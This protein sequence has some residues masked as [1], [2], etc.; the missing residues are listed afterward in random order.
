M[1]IKFSVKELS[2]IVGISSRNIRYYD[3]IGLFKCSGNLDNGYRYYTID[4]IEEIYII[5][6]LRHMG[7]SIKEIKSHLENRNIDEYDSI[8]NNQLDKV[9]AEILKL[10]RIQYQIK[11]RI[12][13]LDFI[14]S[15]PP[16]G[17]I[18]VQTLPAL[19]IIKLEKEIK[20]QID[21]EVAIRNIDSGEGLPTGAF[22]GDIGFFVDMNAVKTRAAEEFT[23]MFLVAD[24]PIYDMSTKTSELKSG[25]WL[26]VFV[27]GDHHEARMYYDDLLDY[28]LE[29]ELEL[30]SYAVERTLIDH[31]ISSDPNLHITE[32]LIP[33]MG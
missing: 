29:H 8:L 1:D 15:I 13:S 19:R 6:Y 23:G 2:Q 7:I 25:K 20:G 32:I 3:D 12:A 9:T 30:D 4:K 22:V 26:S 27:K 17:E 33:I 18:F 31:Y 14:R 5:N 24:D 28:A 11:R 16:I 10:Q 21:W